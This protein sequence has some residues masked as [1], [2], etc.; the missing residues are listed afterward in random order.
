MR[1]LTF[2]TVLLY[3]FSTATSA[4]DVYKCTDAQGNVAFQDQPCPAGAVQAQVWLPDAQ[5]APAQP[6]AA[7]PSPA[8]AN[9]PPAPAPAPV[10][11]PSAP[12]PPVWICQKAEDGSTYFS[13][14]GAPPVRYV[15]L[16]VLGY[17]GH[18]LAQAYGP[19]GIGVSAPELRQVPISTSPHDA[20]A[21]G[22]TPLQDHCMRASREQTCSWL[23]KQYDDVTHKLRNAF[24]DQRAI[25]QP[26]ADE[27][28]SQRN[29][30]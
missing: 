16:G 19:G 7:T 23:Q 18:S 12:L 2:C 26:Q 25:L 1:V 8:E 15:P 4:T 5:P 22:Y 21:S 14:N 3:P 17:P 29:G 28:E 9:P 27:L 10:A 6:V 13:R 20:I 30:C 24:K 11:R